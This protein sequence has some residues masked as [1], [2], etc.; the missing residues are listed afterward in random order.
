MLVR[1]DAFIVTGF[2]IIVSLLQRGF[3][4]I[5]YDVL[6][7]LSIFMTKAI[8]VCVIAIL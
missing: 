4:I 2:G 5:V 6:I 3:V 8:S 1:G 7:S